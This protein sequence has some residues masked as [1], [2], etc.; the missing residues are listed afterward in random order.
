MYNSL[1]MY[2]KFYDIQFSNKQ[3]WPHENKGI[4]NSTLQNIHDKLSRYC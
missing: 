2:H 3:N 1:H 4:E